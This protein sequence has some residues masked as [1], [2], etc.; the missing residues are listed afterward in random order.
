MKDSVRALTRIYI[1]LIICP[2]AKK[3]FVV[4]KT[5]FWKWLPL[6]SPK[7]LLALQNSLRREK[8]NNSKKLI[9]TAVVRNIF[10]L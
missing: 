5:H 9:S 10:F 2:F 3:S 1:F 6:E 7:H 8:K 4:R